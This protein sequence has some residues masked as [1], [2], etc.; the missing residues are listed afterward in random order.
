MSKL[1]DKDI[2]LIL[3]YLKQYIFRIHYILGLKQEELIDEEEESERLMKKKN[4]WLENIK[5]AERGFNKLIRIPKFCL[6][7]NFN[8]LLGKPE[9]K[10]Q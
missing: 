2:E 10:Q 8:V 4:T 9:K 3:Y 5:D 6:A 1:T 7:N